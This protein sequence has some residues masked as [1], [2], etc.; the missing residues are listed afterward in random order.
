MKPH[1]FQDLRAKIVDEIAE[2]AALPLAGEDK[3]KA[4]VDK[5][6]EY[7]D[8]AITFPPTPAGAIAEMGRASVSL[9]HLFA[10]CGDAWGPVTA[11]VVA[12]IA[13]SKAVAKAGD[14]VA[15]TPGRWH[16]VQGW[17]GTPF[18]SGVT[19]HTI[20]VYAPATGPKVL[21]FDSAKDRNERVAWV[22]WSDYAAQ[23]RGGQ[24]AC[25]LREVAQ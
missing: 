14:I 9:W 8:K 3:R 2:A 1:V 13:D 15:L 24:A 22:V 10:D 12:G 11:C 7:A 25:A 6:V 20:T 18:G 5:I 23:Y 21:V 16:R 4:V 17:R 19:G